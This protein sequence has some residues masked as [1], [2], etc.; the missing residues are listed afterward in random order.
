MSTKMKLL[1]G[2]GVY[3]LGCIVIVVAT[4]CDEDDETILEVFSECRDALSPA[5]ENNWPT[6]SPRQRIRSRRA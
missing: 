3:I 2:F 5:D 4:G 1:I 6:G